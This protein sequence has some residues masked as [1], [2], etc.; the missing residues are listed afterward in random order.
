MKSAETTTSLQTDS[1]TTL[2]V[3]PA[4]VESSGG[5][6]PYITIIGGFILIGFVAWLYFRPE[7]RK[8]RAE[9]RQRKG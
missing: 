1:H 2:Q 3:G 4:K 6:L 7:N 9:K 5:M 8:R